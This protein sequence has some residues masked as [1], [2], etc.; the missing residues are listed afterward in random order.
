MKWD[1]WVGTGDGVGTDSMSLIA[2]VL[3]MC[4]PCSSMFLMCAFNGV[5]LVLLY[6]RLRGSSVRNS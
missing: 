2:I 5:E 3:A 1:G 6:K 4:E